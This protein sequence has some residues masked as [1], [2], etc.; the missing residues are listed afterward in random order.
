ML[1]HSFEMRV[2]LSP[3]CTQLLSKM[4]L[5]EYTISKGIFILRKKLNYEIL[6]HLFL[7]FKIKNNSS[8]CIIFMHL[9]AMS[10]FTLGSS[11]RKNADREHGPPQL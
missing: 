1:Q 8:K 4:L 5:F 11:L 6:L 7:K 10:I 3:F 2:W 9:V